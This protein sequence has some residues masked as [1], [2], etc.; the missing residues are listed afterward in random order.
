MAKKLCGEGLAWEP[1]K[2]VSLQCYEHCCLKVAASTLENLSGESKDMKYIF[3]RSVH[4]CFLFVMFCQHFCENRA[5]T[6]AQKA[7]GSQILQDWHT[8]H[9]PTP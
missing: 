8:P 6:P 1:S 2:K 4:I 7:R 5:I 3:R 9:T